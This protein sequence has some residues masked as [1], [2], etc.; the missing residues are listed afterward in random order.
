VSLR[1]ASAGQ[2]EGGDKAS[3]G[4]K[5]ARAESKGRSV[6]GWEQCKGWKS[7]Q[8]GGT[9]DSTRW[10]SISYQ[11]EGPGRE[12]GRE[13]TGR[14]GGEG[15]GDRGGGA[16]GDTNT[17]SYGAAENISFNPNKDR[18]GSLEGKRDR[19]G[20]EMERKDGVGRGSAHLT[21][22]VQAHRLGGGVKR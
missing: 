14:Y 6:K 11:W 9:E 3:K 21:L 16:W 15:G 17:S 5:I 10:W 20:M 13:G 4:A 18:R 19:G 1:G 8:A 7:R 12:Q 22:V 2:V